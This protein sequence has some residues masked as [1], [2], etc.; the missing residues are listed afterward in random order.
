MKKLPLIGGLVAVVALGGAG[1]IYYAGQKAETEIKN[2]Q[3]EFQKEVISLLAGDSIS[4]VD[5]K[6]NRSFLSSDNQFTILIR[7]GIDASGNEKPP[8][9]LT[10]KQHIKHGPLLNTATGFKTGWYHVDYDLDLP[11]LFAEVA[12]SD[13]AFA[14]WISKHPK[15]VKLG[16]TVGLNEDRHVYLNTEALNEKT[17]MGTFEI[18]AA[19][20]QFTYTKAQ[21]QIEFHFELPKLAVNTTGSK[22]ENILLEGLVY[23]GKTEPVEGKFNPLAGNSTLKIASISASGMKPS[24]PPA[25]PI[26]APASDTAEPAAK[27]YSVKMD[28]LAFTYKGLL[29]DGFFDLSYLYELGNCEKCDELAINQKPV[30]SAKFGMELNHIH[31]ASISGLN[32]TI[33]NLYKT[34]LIDTIKSKGKP[35]TDQLTAQMAGIGMVA[36]T[37]LTTIAKNDPSFK[38]STVEV[39]TKDGAK[40]NMSASATLKGLTDM[41]ISGGNPMAALKKLYAESS[42]NFD[43][44]LI[45]KEVLANPSLDKLIKAGWL[46]KENN[47]LLHSF[48][49]EGGKIT[50]F[51]KTYQSI[52]ELEAAAVQMQ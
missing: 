21:D 37:N 48:K 38:I 25:F 45:P 2:A 34:M 30:K 20:Q 12:K 9:K 26:E 42:A 36:L 44:S 27:P 8:V 11:T 46:K 19:S 29:K 49:F 6:Y 3:S 10:I 1:S 16:Y 41:D 17:A 32:E 24:L 5:T 4:I 23:D 13:A 35:N 33:A 52:A 14:N 18:A 31:A 39:E 22:Q 40:A 28:N 7:D 43:W 15:W 47:H 51:D 50:I